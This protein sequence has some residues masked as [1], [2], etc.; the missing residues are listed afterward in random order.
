M[1]FDGKIMD[2]RS[3]T[4]N[5]KTFRNQLIDKNNQLNRF[6]GREDITENHQTVCLYFHDASMFSEEKILKGYEGMK[7]ILK[8][9]HTDP[10][11][12]DVVC[13]INKGDSIE[14]KEYNF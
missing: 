9:N 13:I 5:S 14:V 1:V 2:I 11:L 6:C 7:R 10:R 3:I 12:K 4:E 8:I